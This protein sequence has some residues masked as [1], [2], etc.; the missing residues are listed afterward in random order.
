MPY[1][2][3][4]SCSPNKKCNSYT[5]YGACFMSK[6]FHSNGLIKYIARGPRAC[7]FTLKRN[8]NKKLDIKGKKSPLRWQE[9]FAYKQR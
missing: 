3:R 2:C 5:L 8:D 1:H 4:I 6:S 7:I 9:S